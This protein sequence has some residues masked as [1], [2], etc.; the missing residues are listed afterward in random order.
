MRLGSPAEGADFFGRQ[1]ELKD[2]WRYL[3][4]DHIQFPGVRRLGKT[5]ILK[6]L[7]ADAPGH[8][9]MAQLIDVSKAKSAADFVAC[10]DK[11]FPDAE[12]KSFIANQA[13][14]VADWFK[15][16]RK[17]EGKIAGNG[18]TLELND[19][20][21]PSWLK[22]AEKLYARLYDQPLLIL[23]DEFPKMLLSLLQRAPQEAEQLLEWLRIWRQ[24]AGH[25]RFVFTGSIGLQVLL[26]RH[27][28]GGTMNDTFPY[29]LGPYTRVEAREFWRYFSPLIDPDTSW[30]FAD[31]GVIDYALD[32]IGWLSPY[33]LSLLL[34]GSRVAARNRRQENQVP[35]SMPSVIEKADVDDAYEI[36]LAK[37][38]V[39]H[40]WENRLKES[41]PADDFRFS[42]AVLTHIS[43]QADGMS[44]KQ[45]SS[46]LTRLEPDPD[47]RTERLQDLLV[48]LTD[49]GYTSPP[50]AK[51]R[52]Q[53]L[54]FLLRDWWSR[55]HV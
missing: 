30:Q 48:R 32:I 50:D 53:F 19:S 36:L 46:R 17:I 34:E 14:A 18:I 43:R 35:E 7:L 21:A 25:C 24:A 28:L 42:C 45:L 37:R 15:R 55:N 33:Y 39:F 40:H 13:K 4:H 54:S 1:Q 2:L 16:I 49:E 10:L 6:K 51:Q 27:G 23:L 20:S 38:S 11:A 29:P 5:S 41:L 26:E 22:G 31:D 8:G 9:V 47:R 44:L 3:E 12:I 52:I